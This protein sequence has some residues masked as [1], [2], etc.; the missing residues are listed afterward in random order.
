MLSL[1]INLLMVH[2]SY[3]VKG[4]S[5]IKL[6]FA[7]T[8]FFLINTSEA[9]NSTFCPGLFPQWSPQATVGGVLGITH[10]DFKSD[11][12]DKFIYGNFLVPVLQSN[13]SMWYLNG[14]QTVVSDC[15]NYT[16]NLGAGYRKIIN[17]SYI[18]G[19]YGF[20]DYEHTQFEN[21]FYQGQ[22]GGEYISP[23]W[24]A[25][26]NGYVPIGDRNKTTNNAPPISSDDQSIIYPGSV[27]LVE[28]PFLEHAEAGG[29]LQVGSA[30]PFAPS[31]LPFVGYYHFG[32]DQNLD[33]SINGGRAGLQYTYNRWLTVFASDQYDNLR[34][35]AVLVGAGVTLG[36]AASSSSSAI[37]NSLME[38]TPFGFS[39]IF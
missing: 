24:Q 10:N 18:L 14:R 6:L 37:V 38:E 11:N 7:V 33:T 30:L 2:R 31:F 17:N 25:R 29:D 23:T 19:A 28:Y 3:I 4:S 32:F 35:N 5:L 34:K 26:V 12:T 20:F 21:N 39:G 1:R 13:D 36:G 15:C 8:A 9:D 22:L 16:T 27:A